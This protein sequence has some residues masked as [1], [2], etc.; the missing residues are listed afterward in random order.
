MKIKLA[1]I[2]VA[3]LCEGAA[4][5]GVRNASNA[6]QSDVAQANKFLASIPSACSRSYA[7]ALADGTIKIR[8]ICSGNG[9]S[10]DGVIEI[11][12]GM[13]TRVK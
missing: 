5:A 9:D 13:V 4:S 2:S 1:F 11:K 10:M 8:V 3:L 7:Y 12:N 6:N